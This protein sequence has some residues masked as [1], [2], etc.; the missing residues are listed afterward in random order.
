MWWMWMSST[1]HLNEPGLQLVVDN[2]VVAITF[3]A[4]LVIVHHRLRKTTERDQS[5]G[6]ER[7]V[8]VIY[9]SENDSARTALKNYSEEKSFSAHTVILLWM[10]WTWWR[11]WH[12]LCHS[13]KLEII[14]S[15]NKTVMENTYN[16]QTGNKDSWVFLQVWP[17]LKIEIKNTQPQPLTATAF[18]D[19]T[20]I[21]WIW[22]KSRLV[23]S[24]PLVLSRYRRRLLT[25]HLPPCTWL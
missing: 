17:N 25:V 23:T 3:K 9:T 18:N 5:V 19:C 15:N 21:Q 24:F 2:D 22:S 20:T 11:N 12:W 10:W 13:W 4:V 1:T 14:L 7:K 8:F 6:R 16:I